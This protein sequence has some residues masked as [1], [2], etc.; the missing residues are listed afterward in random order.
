MVLFLSG[1]LDAQERVF[2]NRE[3]KTVTGAV[4]TVS[5]GIVQLEINGGIFEVPFQSLSD[6]DQAYLRDWVAN[7]YPYKFDLRESDHRD[8][9]DGSPGKPPGCSLTGGG[10]YDPGRRALP[11]N[12]R[13]MKHYQGYFKLILSNR[14]GITAKNLKVKYQ[15]VSV[16]RYTTRGYR[17]GKDEE[18]TMVQTGE[19][20]VAQIAHTRSITLQ[21]D[22]VYLPD[23]KWETT[24]VIRYTDG[25]SD[26]KPT[27]HRNRC[28]LH[29][30]MVR[31]YD[32]NDRELFSYVGPGKYM[33]DQKWR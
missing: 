9:L 30:I 17:G 2:T 27:D 13:S 1:I 16:Q 15:I 6:E 33:E 31:V 32:E 12:S 23:S 11:S 28:D 5:N 18:T 8:N 3:G 7:N 22:P 14:S 19:M 21:T 29:G 20:D 10:I 4:E 26:N 25:T 24:S